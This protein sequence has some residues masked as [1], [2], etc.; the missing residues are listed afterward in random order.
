MIHAWTDERSRGGTRNLIQ[1]GGD[2]AKKKGKKREE[3][4][5]QPEAKAPAIEL[6]QRVACGRAARQLP[7]FLPPVDQYTVLNAM[8][9]ARH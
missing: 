9:I 7:L 6:V 4:P 2:R 8:S 5:G 3:K 1:R